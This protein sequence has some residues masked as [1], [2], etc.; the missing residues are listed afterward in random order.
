M[1]EWS[2]VVARLTDVD[3]IP[4]HPSNRKPEN[5]TQDGRKLRR[6]K[7]TNA[8]GQLST[9]LAGCKT[10]VVCAFAGKIYR[11]VPKFYQPYMLYLADKRGFGIAS[12]L[13]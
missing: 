6:Y 2:V 5:K 3:L 12:N 8:G 1:V 9:Q 4:P 11:N 10:P 13:I 7:L